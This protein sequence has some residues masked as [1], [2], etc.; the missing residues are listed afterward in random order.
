[1]KAGPPLEL[2]VM[3]TEFC[4]LAFQGTDRRLQESLRLVAEGFEREA[5]KVDA[6]SLDDTI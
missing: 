4:E 3:A 1:M 2:R 5:D 6:L